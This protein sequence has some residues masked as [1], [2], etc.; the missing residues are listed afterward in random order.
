M[1]KDFVAGG[2]AYEFVVRDATYRGMRQLDGVNYKITLQ[3]TRGGWHYTVETNGAALSRIDGGTAH[4][5][6]EM[7]SDAVQAL[8]DARL[9]RGVL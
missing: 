4:E 5:C 8:H 2:I 3:A 7:A 9:R 6:G 1:H